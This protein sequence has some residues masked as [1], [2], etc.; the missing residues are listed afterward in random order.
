MRI[1]LNCGADA[2][3]GPG[4]VQ[5]CA[6]CDRL[7]AENI[8]AAQAE[9]AAAKRAPVVKAICAKC[10]RTRRIVAD[11]QC[12]TCLNREARRVNTHEMY[13]HGRRGY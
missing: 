12:G 11:G 7:A 3:D 4:Y 13:G 8:A 2:S 6:T 10:G 9:R 5:I 1:C